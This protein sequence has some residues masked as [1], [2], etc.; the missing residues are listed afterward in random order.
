MKTLILNGSPHPNGDTMFLVRALTDR[1]HGECRI[2]HCYAAR[3]AP[4]ADCRA[5]REQDMCVIADEMQAVYPLMEE[6]DNLILASPI[7]YASLTG[8]LLDVVSRVQRYD[9]AK[10]F[11]HISPPLKPKK[12]AVILTCGGSGGVQTASAAANIILRELGAKEVFAPICSTHTDT[13][14]ASEDAAALRSVQEAA[15]WFH[16]AGC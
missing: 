7:Y 12:G 13:V 11:R 10:R 8:R 9:A 5:C 6:C 16:Q 15:A 1:L 2:I 3:I 14:P 4:C